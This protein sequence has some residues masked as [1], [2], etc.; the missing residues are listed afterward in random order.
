M[1]VPQEIREVIAVLQA[2]PQG[3]ESSPFFKGGE[4]AIQGP[5]EIAWLAENLQNLTAQSAVALHPAVF[6]VFEVGLQFPG[7]TGVMV[8]VSHAAKRAYLFSMHKINV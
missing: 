7:S 2:N 4:H 8:V 6:G 3:I 5:A 1:A